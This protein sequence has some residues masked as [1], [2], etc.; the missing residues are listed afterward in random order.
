MGRAKVYPDA[1][2]KQRAY[3]ARLA[4]EMVLVNRRRWAALEGRVNRLADA[5]SGA[6]SAGCPMAREIRGAATDT[7]LDSL[8]GWFEGQ[9]ADARAQGRAASSACGGLRGEGEGSRRAPVEEGTS[10]CGGSGDAPVG[11]LP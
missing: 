3:R 4:E 2:A 10:L 8:T 9:A 1:A 5:V 6:R 11:R 7:I